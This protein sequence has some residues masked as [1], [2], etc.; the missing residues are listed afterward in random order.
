LTVVPPAFVTL[1]VEPA[2]PPTVNLLVTLNVPGL[3]LNIS[4]VG[5]AGV[6]AVLAEVIVVKLMSIGPLPVILT[7]G[8]EEEAVVME[9]EPTT[10]VM[11]PAP[12]A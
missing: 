10:A 7:A 6:V 5:V 3:V 12:L 4:A 8:C 9:L 11:S 1:A 2:A